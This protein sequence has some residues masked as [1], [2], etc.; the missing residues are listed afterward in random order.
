VGRIK[1]LTGGEGADLA[2]E[3]VGRPRTITQAAAC[4]ARS[5]RA[6]LVGIGAEP[7]A[8]PPTAL[9]SVLGHALLGSLGYRREDVVRLVRL[10]SGGRLDLSGSI[11]ARRPLAEINE[12]VRRLREKVENPVRIMVCPEL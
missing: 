6:V 1:E 10:V 8:A 3:L 9:F 4:L 12:G 7:I 5:G 11:S 2:V